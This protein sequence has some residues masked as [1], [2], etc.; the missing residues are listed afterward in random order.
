MPE[1]LETEEPIDCR[2][3][4]VEPLFAFGTLRDYPYVM[5]MHKQLGI[6]ENLL[7]QYMLVVRLINTME[8]SEFKYTGLTRFR[9]RSFRSRLQSAVRKE[10]PPPMNG[11]DT[12][13]NIIDVRDDVAPRDCYA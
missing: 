9:L 10:T 11:W 2:K 5:S 8:G 7:D 6:S 13:Y 3:T 12:I 1:V 4:N